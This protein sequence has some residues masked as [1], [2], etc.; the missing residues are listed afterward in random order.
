MKFLSLLAFVLTLTVTT[1]NADEPY[2]VQVNAHDYRF[3]MPSTMK[4]GWVTFDFHNKGNEMHVAILGK[5]PDDVALEDFKQAIKNL[6]DIPF[7]G[8]G[9]PG[10]H[11][12][13]QHSKTAI[14]LPPGDYV[15]LCGTRN[16]A[17]QSH[18]RLGMVHY[19]E[20]TDEPNH[21]PEPKED[22]NLTL[23]MFD[24]ATDAPL[25]PGSNT[26]RIK[27]NTG[28]FGDVH[29]VS[30]NAEASLDD[31]RNYLEAIKEPAPP[32]FIGGIEQGDPNVVQY[33]TVELE[34]GRYGWISHEAAGY[35]INETFTVAN[36]GNAKAIAFDDIEHEMKLHFSEQGMTAP[37]TVPASRTLILAETTDDRLH[38]PR[39]MR[40]HE[41][42]TAEDARDYLIGF[43][44]NWLAGKL[45]PDEG[46]NIHFDDFFLFLPLHV[47]ENEI[48]LALEPGTYA[49][50]CMGGFGTEEAHHKHG[51]LHTFTVTAE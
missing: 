31:A 43:D 20:V 2:V 7:Q 34:E 28:E 1:A 11:S 50:V 38:A 13:G 48:S 15:L 29:L 19:F 40:M 12:P 35:G 3:E 39:I 49:L 5:R 27:N 36:D 4:S 16:A 46:L 45:N 47:P 18:F 26:I 32:H 10:L 37:D 21:A 51:G 6:R 17:G 23:S 30:L 14:N 25:R 8:H 22:V 42:Y 33:L 9:G 24:V 44:K 41:G